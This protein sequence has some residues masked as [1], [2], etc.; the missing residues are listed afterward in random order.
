MTEASIYK[1]VESFH[2]GPLGLLG[3]KMW[4]FLKLGVCNYRDPNQGC[5][6]IPH[7]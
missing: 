6:T 5:K 2:F 3:K 1:V 7:M 4:M